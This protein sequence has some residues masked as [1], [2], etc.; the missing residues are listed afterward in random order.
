MKMADSFL[1]Q[2]YLNGPTSRC[3]EKIAVTDGS[4]YVSYRELSVLSNN[5]S[6]CL[7]AMGV[8]RQD[9]VAICLQ[10]SVGCLSAI[11]GVLKADAIYIPL[12][13]K[14]PVERLAHC[15][16][17]AAPAA[18]LCDSKTLPLARAAMADI[19]STIPIM[20]LCGNGEIQEAVVGRGEVSAFDG[21]APFCLNNQNDIAYILYT[22]GST[23]RPKGVMISHA[24]VKA[25]IDWA[26]AFF[27][28]GEQDNILGTAPFHFDM[29]TF[30]IYCALK[31]G[32]TFCIANEMQSL[33]PEKLVEFIERQQ[34]TLWKGVSSLLMYMARAGVLRSGS[35]PTL[36]QVV[37]AGETLPTRYLIDW[38]RA[39]PEKTFYNGYGPTETTGVSTCYRVNSVPEGPHVR[40]PIG[41]PRQGAR[42]ILLSE[43]QAEVPVGEIGELCIAGRG[44]ARGYL[45][46]P[47]KT[48]RS[49]VPDPLSSSGEL[50]YKTGDLARLLADGNLEYLGRKDRQLKFMGYRI[51]AGEIEHALLLI[52]Q[53]KD[54]AVDLIE[55]ELNEG[56]LE[57]AAFLEADGE[58]DSEIDVAL[59]SARLKRH[60][61]GYM[62]PRRFIRI[63]KMPRCCRGKIRLDILRDGCQTI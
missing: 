41:V 23:G 1:L 11:L 6:H 60:L 40:M 27:N 36:K 21:S 34:V 12:D 55:S 48:A 39:F 47:E 4:N 10:R 14:A 57:L 13:H 58:S 62:I 29:S 44:L 63:E 18:V 52:P 32:A 56:V 2:Q 33:F 42:V 8:A 20:N 43:E 9:R 22:S 59:I 61:P 25:Y 3:P 24:N 19:G 54:T 16:K 15:M 26:S 50:I 51:E 46:D 5:I 38:M 45:N 7:K 35:M 49:F 30:D 31:A 37:F 28:I 53:I 17:D